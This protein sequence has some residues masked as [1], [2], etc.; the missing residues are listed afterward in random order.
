VRKLEIE[1]C[2]EDL[3]W[4]TTMISEEGLWY[5]SPSYLYCNWILVLHHAYQILWKGR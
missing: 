4:I 1:V 2:C 5:N 3:L